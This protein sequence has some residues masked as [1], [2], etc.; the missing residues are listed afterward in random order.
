[1]SSLRLRLSLLR[2]D[3][4]DKVTREAP[5]PRRAR[6]GRIPLSG[7]QQDVHVSEEAEGPQQESVLQGQT[8]VAGSSQHQ[9]L[10]ILNARRTAMLKMSSIALRPVKSRETGKEES[11]RNLVMLTSRQFKSVLMCAIP[12]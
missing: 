2:E 6:D 12:M 3:L 4:P 1:M 8:A 7:L 11:E 5:H 10:E 9:L